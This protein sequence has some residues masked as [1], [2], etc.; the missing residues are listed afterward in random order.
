MQHTTVRIQYNFTTHITVTNICFLI[1]LWGFMLLLTKW[2]PCGRPDKL[3]T[4]KHGHSAHNYHSRTRSCRISASQSRF[5][6][7]HARVCFHY[8][9]RGFMVHSVGKCSSSASG[10]PRELLLHQNSA[11]INHGDT[12]RDRR[13]TM[14]YYH[15]NWRDLCSS[16]RHTIIPPE[17]TTA[18]HLDILSSRLK[19]PPQ[20]T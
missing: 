7:A 20:F 10:F 15:P 5:L 17:E 9:P 2:N 8:I 4:V 6:T 19:K 12:L 3:M 14:T 18:V 1:I 11:W 13:S 16:P